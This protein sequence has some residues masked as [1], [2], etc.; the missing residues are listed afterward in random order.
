MNGS[1]L[2]ARAALNP[3]YVAAIILII[4]IVLAALYVITKMLADY[5]ASPAYLEK[6]K[7]KPTTFANV[8]DTA[9][10]AHLL[11]E[12]RDLLW[13]ICKKNPTPNLRYYLRDPLTLEPLFKATFEFLDQADDEKSKTYL[14]SLR[15]KLKDTFTPTE[16]MNNSR[17]IEVG[18]ELTYTASQGVHYRLKLV[19]KQPDSMILALPA[20]MVERGDKP[21][22]L[23]KITLI[24]IHKSGNAYQMETRAVRY[25][26][27]KQNGEQMIIMHSENL[28]PL[29]RRQTERTDIEQPCLFASVAVKKNE[30]G[31]NSTV[32]YTPSENLHKGI[33]MDV[34]TGGCRITTTMPIKPEQ[35]I[36]IRG[37]FNASDEDAVIGTIVRTT[38]RLDGLFILHIRFVK[39]EREVENRIQALVCQ[40]TLPELSI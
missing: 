5:K 14:F 36:Y 24:F 27:D 19:E 35:F 11:R 32:S 15:G 3:L 8:N 18:T 1:P 21:Q 20:V 25:Q 9:K 12:E 17:K 37:K 13:S 22:E 33:L 29:Q 2:D 23:S 31:K 10:L 38:K 34:S 39:I 30:T 26:K 7:N 6:Q 28:S 4:F 16:N 40:Y